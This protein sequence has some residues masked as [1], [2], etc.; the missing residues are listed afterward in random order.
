MTC[1]HKIGLPTPGANAVGNQIGF[2]FTFQSMIGEQCGESLRRYHLSPASSGFL[3]CYQGLLVPT[4]TM[5]TNLS[6]SSVE[7][8][9]LVS[10]TWHYDAPRQMRFVNSL[11]FEFSLGFILSR[12]VQGSHAVIQRGPHGKTPARTILQFTFQVGLPSSRM[13]LQIHPNMPV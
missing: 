7:Q 8:R 11:N 2:R 12:F 5:P 10:D 4:S 13:V 1:W 3:A 9:K 6:A